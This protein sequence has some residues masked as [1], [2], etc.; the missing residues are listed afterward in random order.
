M[1][2]R[3]WLGTAKN[4]KQVSTITMSGTWSGGDT[5]T[6]TI[7]TLELVVTI[8][9]LTTTT[10]VATTL[11]E[12][13]NGTT[14]TDTSASCTPTIG[15]GGGVSMGPFAELTATSNGAVVTLTGVTAGVPVVVAASDTAA[16]G[17]ATAATTTAATGCNFW[18]NVDNWSGG[19]V[20]VDN[21][22]VVFDSGDV[23]LLYALT[24]SIQPAAVTITKGYRGSIG[25]PDWNASGGYSE[26]RETHLTFDDNSVTTTYKI[27]EGQGR[28]S[29]RI[30]ID[31]GS[32]RINATVFGTGQRLASGD[33]SAPLQLLGTHAS[34]A[35][36]VLGGD[37][38][39]A[40]GATE[41]AVVDELRVS[42]GDAGSGVRV[43]CGAGVTFGDIYQDGGNLTV[44]SAAGIV[45]VT[46]GVLKWLS[47]AI[48]TL[49]VK[50]GKVQH[51]GTGTIGTVSVYS[52]TFD[53]SGD[54]RAF[55]ITNEV[56]LYAGASVLDPTFAAAM[57]NGYKVNCRMDQLGKIDFGPGRTFD[58]S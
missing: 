18:D 19:A 43:E 37:V 14:L 11:K 1:A 17:T 8:G 36:T 38:G 31:A 2:T 12:A 35:V 22:T 26:Y 58:V 49:A 45:E 13:F 28:G 46:S 10:Q 53:R 16:S 3:R 40:Q 7:G 39:I 51:Y 33:D 42:T 44:S 20:P 24:T 6:V 29:S 41:T 34:N 52:A 30:R 47:G 48:T 21:D 23:D 27:G 5:V 32:G 54:N 4:V 56:Q 15:E 50:G 9:S 55:A 25:L 57:G